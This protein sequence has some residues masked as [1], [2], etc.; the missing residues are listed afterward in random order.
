MMLGPSLFPPHRMHLKTQSARPTV[1]LAD[2]DRDVLEYTT[3]LLTPRYNI[4]ATVSNG[5][6]A[7]DAVL[8]LNPDVAVL[9]IAMPVLDGFEA[10]RKMRRHSCRTS[11]VFLTLSEDD[12]YIAAA[13]EGGALGYVLKPFIYSDLVPAIENAL[14]GHVFVSSRPSSNR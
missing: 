3:R 1:V 14:A 2:D 13:L 9:D 12:D 8:R 11:I 7:V 5:M 10:H 4:V 6:T